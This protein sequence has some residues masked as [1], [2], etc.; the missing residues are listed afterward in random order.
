MIGLLWLVSQTVYNNFG[1]QQEITCQ[2][3]AKKKDNGKFRWHIEE[4]QNLVTQSNWYREGIWRQR[5]DETL[6]K[7]EER[8][9]K[10]QLLRGKY[11]RL[12]SSK[13]LLEFLIPEYEL[14]LTI[15]SFRDKDSNHV[16]ANPLKLEPAVSGRFF[17][18]SPL[19]VQVP[20]VQPASV[21]QVIFPSHEQF[22]W[23]QGDTHTVRWQ[24]IPRGIMISIY[25]VFHSENEKTKLTL[26]HNISSFGSLPY[27]M[28]LDGPVG[29]H[30]KIRIVPKNRSQAGASYNAES[31]GF[32]IQKKHSKKIFSN[33][34]LAQGLDG[35][36]DYSKCPSVLA[37]AK[38][39][40]KDSLPSASRYNITQSPHQS[41]AGVQ[42]INPSQRL[43]WT[44]VSSMPKE[45]PACH[46]HQL[47][48]STPSI[49]PESES[50][51]PIFEL[52][53]VQAS[54]RRKLQ[55]QKQDGAIF[56]EDPILTRYSLHQDGEGKA[57]Q[58]SN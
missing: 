24:G 1:F 4:M 37:S 32:S 52:A 22:T 39:Y 17:L 31:C 28:P 11:G 25:L 45:S 12:L 41:S 38:I 8:L 29:Y 44:S 5:A 23:Y 55:I 27:R 20:R 30:F 56:R 47:H 46:G 49:R 14:S 51:M 33:V 9:L 6:D 42:G 26:V 19:V 48:G 36:H 13:E 7:F 2:Q 54:E 40:L 3:L 21:P 15:D 53:A 35:V 10:Q 43:A 57:H 50:G 58:V 16:F 34:A 18:L